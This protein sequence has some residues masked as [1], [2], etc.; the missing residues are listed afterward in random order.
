MKNLLYGGV[1]ILVVLI[2]SCSKSKDT[3][4]PAPPTGG[5]S[6]PPVTTVSTYLTNAKATHDFVTANY[7]T[8]YG[9]Y[10][11]NTTTNVNSAFEWYNASQLYADAAMVGLGDATYTTGMNK[12]FAWL[13]NLI[14]KNDVNGGYFAFANLDGSGGSG[15]KYVDDDSLTG[16]AYLEAY[17]VTTG[18]TQTNYLNAAKACANWLMNSGQWDTTFGG[19]FWWATDKTVKP[20]QS[21]ALALQ[22]FLRLYKITGQSVYH[23]WAVSVNNW[24]NSQMYDSATGLYIWQIEKNGTKDLAKFTYDNAIMLEAE[25]L[26]V[27]AMND[28]TYLTKAQALGNAMIKTL[29][30]ANHNVFIFNTTDIRI[31]PCYCVWASQAM[32]KLY[33]A[34]HNSSWLT[35]A[36]ANIDQINVVMKSPASGYYQYA[37][38][39]GAGRYT[40]MEGVDQAWM[41]R[42]QTLLSKYK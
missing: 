8:A 22:L 34:D 12:T 1:A 6:T 30:D 31:N 3:P 10:R 36:K 21:N 20:T 17:D 41:Q 25:L 33:E 16:M 18:T 19:G 26:Y 40:N 23:D 38:L 5:G 37:G 24:L 32:I 14:D 29:W 11:V 4:S 2:A 7:L 39:D 13:N 15:T 42:V 35:Y 9:S 27:Q 28:D